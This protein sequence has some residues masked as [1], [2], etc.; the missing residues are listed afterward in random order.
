[1]GVQSDIAGAVY[2]YD[3]PGL[4]QSTVVM[5]QIGVKMGDPDLFP[6]EVLNDILNSFG[7][8]LFDQIR[9]R[10]VTLPHSAP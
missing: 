2:L 1:M 9:S 10:E 6:L 5:G 3:R 7:G 4:T 8:R